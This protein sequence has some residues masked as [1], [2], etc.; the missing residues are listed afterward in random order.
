M[1]SPGAGIPV[2]TASPLTPE[3]PIWEP[4][5]YRGRYSTFRPA[6]GY[7]ESAEIGMGPIGLAFYVWDYGTK[8]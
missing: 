4:L 2:V 5:H 8:Q 7:R 1:T 6:P 3:S